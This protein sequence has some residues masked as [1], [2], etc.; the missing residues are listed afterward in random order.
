MGPDIPQVDADFFFGAV[1]RLVL[2]KAR[3]KPA[4]PGERPASPPY[5]TILAMQTIEDHRLPPKC[6]LGRRA[7]PTPGQQ[8]RFQGQD[9]QQ[10]AEAVAHPGIVA[11]RQ[12]RLT[13][14]PVGRWS[15][16]C[17]GGN[18]RRTHYSGPKL[19]GVQPAIEACTRHSK[20]PDTTGSGQDT[21]KPQDMVCLF[22]L[23]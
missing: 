19:T 16:L 17:G 21:E 7:L 4:G 22:T 6:P 11:R 20:P 9:N 3:W 2:P 8:R 5:Q 23:Q 1:G 10:R 12:A 18:R 14:S 13:S 15:L